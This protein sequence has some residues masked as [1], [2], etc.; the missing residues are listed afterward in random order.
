MTLYGDKD[1][2]NMLHSYH[3]NPIWQS[4]VGHFRGAFS[5]INKK[6]SRYSQDDEKQM[7]KGQENAIRC[8][9]QSLVCQIG[10]AAGKTVR[11]PSFKHFDQTVM[12][13]WPDMMMR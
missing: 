11:F 7:I 2:T 8:S 10:E 1:K 9:D 13:R 4:E 3:L 5:S 6:D 12:I